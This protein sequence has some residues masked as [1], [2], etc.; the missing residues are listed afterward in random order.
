MADGHAETVLI[1][2]I[3]N[4]ESAVKAAQAVVAANDEVAASADRAAAATKG[5]S[6]E[7][8]AASGKTASAAKKSAVEQDAASKSV[9]AANERAAASSKAAAAKASVSWNKAG[10]SMVGVGKGITKYVGAPLLLIGAAATKM[11]LDYQKSMLLVETHTDTSRKMVERYK[12][13]ILEMSASGKYTQGPKEFADAMYHIASD[14]YKGTKALKALRESANL[15]MLGQSGLAETTYAVV[16]AM[17]TGIK[18]TQDLHE[19][20][21]ILNGTMGAGDTKMGEITAALSTGVVPAAR[22]AGLGLKDVGASLAFLTARGVPAQKAAYGLSMNFQQ[23]TPYT[24]KSVG[25]FEH[26]HLGLYQLAKD[27]EG[28]NGFLA[29][30]KDL[31]KHL[32]GINKYERGT[33]LREIF[34]G[35]RTSRSILAIQQELGDLEATYKRMED[36]AGKTDKN[37]AI[38]RK[39]PANQWKE[40]WA[41]LQTALV[42]VG[43]QLIPVIIPAMKQIAG[44]VRDV[45][46]AFTTLP[47]GVQS[48]GIKIGLAA[49]ALGPVLAIVGKITQGVS[50]IIKLWEGVAAAET[51]AGAAGAGAGAAGAAGAAG[52]VAAGA[53]GAGVGAVV[54]GAEGA[55]GGVLG[56]L[57]K[58]GAAEGGFKYAGRMLATGVLAVAGGVIVA[59]LGKKGLEAMGV[60]DPTEGQG[61]IKGLTHGFNT[62]HVAATEHHALKEAKKGPYQSG[63]IKNFG[64]VGNTA[65][66][67]GLPSKGAAKSLLAEY[68]KEMRA[69]AKETKVRL[70]DVNTHLRIGLD[71]TDETFRKGTKPWRVHTVKAMEATVAAIKGGMQEGTIKTKAGQERIN[72]LLGS[73]HIL[74]GDDP[75]GLAKGAASTFQKTHAIT[76]KG[77]QQ[78]ITD[79]GQMPKAAREKSVDANRKILE[80][81]AQ[82]HPKIES[83]V[84]HLSAFLIHKFGATNQQLREGVQKGATGPVAKAYEELAGGVGGALTNIGVNTNAMLKAVGA[85]DMVQF[86]AMVLGPSRRPQL[87]GEASQQAHQHGTEFAVGGILGGSGLR[88][89]VPVMAA[90]G[91]AFLTRH[92]QPEVNAGL[93]IGKMMGATKNGS[94]GELFSGARKP[95]YMAQGGSVTVS[96][97]RANANV[98][99]S[100]LGKSLAGVDKYLAAHMEPQRVLQMFHF[101]QAQAA[102]GYPYV[103]GGGHGSFNGPYDCS[104]Y[105]SAILHAGGFLSSPMAVQQGSGLYT[106]GAPGKGKYFTWGVEGTSGAAAHTMMSVKGP[107]G[108]LGY[109]EAGGSGGGAHET[110][111]WDGSFSFRHMPGFAKGGMVA[112]GVAPENAPTKVKAA[113]KKWGN[114]AFDPRSPHFVGW[115]YAKG[116]F[117]GDVLGFSTGGPVPPKAGEIVGASTYGGPADTVSNPTY[118]AWGPSH[119]FAGHNAFAELAM[120]HALGGLNFGTKLKISRAGQSVIAEKMDIGLGGGDAGGKNRAIDLHYETGVALGVLGGGTNAWLG[121]VKVAP[122]D[123][124]AA[125]GGT[126]SKPP[127]PKVVEGKWKVPTGGVGPGKGGKAEAGFDIRKYKVVTGTLSFPSDPNT[128]E[129]CTKEIEHLRSAVLPE[130]HRA[131]RDAKRKKHPDKEVIADL[132][133]NVTLI[134]TRIQKIVKLKAKMVGEKMREKKVSKIEGRGA[135]PNVESII[136][137]AESTYNEAT[138]YAEQVSSLEPSEEGGGLAGYISGKEGPAFKAVLEAENQ[139]RNSVLTGEE[140]AGK[141][142]AGLEAQVAHIEG[143]KDSNKEAYKKEFFKLAPLKSAIEGIKQ[144]YTAPHT[145][146]KGENTRAIPGGGSLEEA[147]IGLQ[148]YGGNHEKL[149]G[150]SLE[151]IAGIFG[152]QIFQ[153]Q[154]TFRE[155]GNRITE[156]LKSEAEKK[157]VEQ[158]EAEAPGKEGALELAEQ[159]AS[160]TGEQNL[161]LNAKNL[162]LAAQY[163]VFQN[164]LGEHAAPYIGAFKTGGFIPGPSSQAYTATVHGG[165]T[166]VPADA[167]MQP[168]VELHLHGDIGSAISSHVPG[169]VKEIDRQMGEQYRHIRYAPS[170]GRTKVRR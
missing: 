122:A 19:T 48:W 80:A 56:G 52:G 4:S 162:T 51:A 139:W 169:L 154:L 78:W 135:M 2:F 14:G 117:V 111:G 101:A 150:L 17:K 94:L 108:K 9:V 104:G 8:S 102:K 130:Y 109:F 99:H 34:G 43:N 77:V 112:G 96:G 145:V 36:I 66:N 3:G 16:S 32:E 142:L 133:K 103:F 47:K 141:R 87:R 156:V 113:I 44:D 39:S 148:G 27:A 132:E 72:A 73:I 37:L 91:E 30:M 71:A 160:A 59:E 50:K 64:A 110:Q 158:E 86:Q 170:G 157:K 68:G 95:H 60:G 93:A 119:P 98:G 136:A 163:K 85:K 38:A 15:A 127:E 46:H 33:V 147:L 138:Q 61:V 146:G 125:S 29:A 18:G 124:S 41:K 83:Q 22:G 11:A 6:A 131:I 89:T 74:K 140:Q 129:G 10:K 40:E 35:G 63:S 65:F 25:A 84:N 12:K 53:E 152:G 97:P 81:W 67:Y 115:G 128:V 126:K 5:A 164:F 23:L 58:R 105:V 121:T 75:F 165:E 49:I 155:M 166:I 82:G 123:G 79:L 161:A 118:G 7:Q 92:D 42:E 134:R 116:G 137:A 69:L 76:S 120:G 62:E 153:T 1:E 70:A 45:V 57:F 90:P 24:E 21:S 149:G 13:A 144:L 106:L 167:A 159:M 107:G 151:P 100:A 20:I 31:H 114:A 143:L 26:L 168:I 28:P 55:A 54:G 88:D